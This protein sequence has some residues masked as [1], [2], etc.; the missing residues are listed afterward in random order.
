MTPPIPPETAGPRVRWVLGSR[1]SRLALAQ[2]RWVEQQLR[3]FAPSLEVV[4]RVVKTTGDLLASAPIASG[5]SVG[6]FVRQLEEELLAGRID[7]AVHSLK[8]LPL[9]QPKGLRIAAVPVRE[10]PH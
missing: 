1:G 10:D 7:L 5:E 8:D 4:I 2:A 6:L 3:H 9:E